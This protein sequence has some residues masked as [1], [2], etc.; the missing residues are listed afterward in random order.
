MKKF[1]SF[2]LLAVIVMAGAVAAFATNAAKNS[3]DESFRGY[4]YDASAPVVKCIE[5]DV[6]CTSTPGQV[7]TWKDDNDV[8]HELRKISSNT[9]CGALLYRPAN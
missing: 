4:Y 1:K 3:D 7:C 2:L 6:Q 9:M 5:T 8:T